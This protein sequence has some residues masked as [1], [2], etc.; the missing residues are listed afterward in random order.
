MLQVYNKH[1]SELL[2]RIIDSKGTFYTLFNDQ[3][4]YSCYLIVS[5]NY[6]KELDTISELFDGREG[7]SCFYIKMNDY[8]RH[9]VYD[10]FEFSAD[11]IY[12]LTVMH[13]SEKYQDD[14]WEQ[15]GNPTMEGIFKYFYRK[16]CEKLSPDAEIAKLE[17]ELEKYYEQRLKSKVGDITNELP[18][19][20]NYY[21]S[22]VIVKDTFE[23]PPKKD[24]VIDLD[25]INDL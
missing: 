21:E 22:H 24:I 6:D 10:N 25:F 9:T 15:E 13:D 16:D 14:Y 20:G 3:N 11:K 18:S 23:L 8:L 1:E 5:D 2:C 7:V 17:K 19:G 12:V 4:Y